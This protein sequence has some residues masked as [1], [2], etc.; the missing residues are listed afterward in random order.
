MSY[1]KD[2]FIT[3]SD[4]QSLSSEQLNRWKEYSQ[5]HYDTKHILFVENGKTGDHPHYHYYGRLKDSKRTNALKKQFINMLFKDR[6]LDKDELKH[7]VV[8]KEATDVIKLVGGYLTKE[9]DYQ[10]HHQKNIDLQWFQ[11]E[12]E[13][14]QKGVKYDKP[15]PIS[16]QNAPFLIEA[17][18]T[19]RM[20][21]EWK[22][23]DKIKNSDVKEAIQFLIQDGYSAHTLVKHIE[24]IRFALRC[25]RKE[26]D[27]IVDD[28]PTINGVLF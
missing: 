9:A 28:L 22:N 7:L 12:C 19:Q 21:E 8:L 4:R 15:R 25:L 2:V 20:G 6:D 10:I 23:K 13:R 24:D 5:K 26:K 14:R 3:V 16:F 1:I 11:K 17:Y 18:M 27:V